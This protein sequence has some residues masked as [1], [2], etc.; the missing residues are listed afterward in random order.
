MLD[1][2][3]IRSNPDDVKKRLRAK[4]VD[5]SLVDGIL[6]L[7]KRRREIQSKSD[8]M[9]KTRNERSKEIGNL[10]KQGQDAS[11]LKEET[12]LLGERI[13]DLDVDLKNIEEEQH[14]LLLT[15]PNMPHESVPVGESEESNA[16]VG[17]WGQ[18]PNFHFEPKPH[19]EIGEKLDILDLPRAT[20]IAG[21]GFPLLKGSLA[22]LERTLISWMLD[23]HSREHG[24]VETAPP[25]LVNRK[26]MTGTGQLPKMEDDMYLCQ[27]DDLFLIPTA[28]VPVTNIHADEIL[29]G[30]QLPVYYV[31]YTPCF[32]REAGSHGK[33]TRGLTRVH[34]FSKVELVK[35]VKP[36]TSYNELETLLKNAEEV[37]R[38][39]GLHYRVVAL[40]SGDLS[41]SAAKCY[42]IEVWAPGMQ[43]Y[44]EVSSCSNF[45]DFQARRAG[46]KFRREAG[47][48]PEFVHT[49]NGSGV[50]LP[51]LMIA[52]LETYQQPDGTVKIPDAIRG[53][54]GADVLK[55]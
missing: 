31:A 9:K 14:Q 20:K 25:Y 24:Y 37:L 6:N 49:L 33:E 32:R 30:A 2:Q 41:F 1:I 34:Q 26:S 43:K 28:E 55:N 7:D 52:L 48:K 39:L 45:E 22:R 50:A 53:I 4:R 16:V 35:L 13:K 42:D 23:L 19:W 51:R 54:F 29:N 27:V 10:V 46:L 18:K 11:A 38:R 15:I 47:A 3:L 5:E 12:R 40:C 36:E 8:E 17:E 44:L 21:S